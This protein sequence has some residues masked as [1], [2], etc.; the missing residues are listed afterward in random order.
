MSAPLTPDR[1]LFQKFLADMFEV[2]QSGVASQSLAATLRL[3]RLISSGNVN[4]DEGIRLVAESAQGVANAAGII[5]GIL[6]GDRL[7][8]RACIGNAASS[9]GQRGMATVCIS[10]NA[11]AVDGEIL[12]VENSETDTRIESAVCRQ[13]G[14][15]A[16]L[17]LPIYHEG[18]VSGVLGVVFDAPH[19]FEPSEVRSYRLMAGLVDEAI[20]QV[21]QHAP[22]KAEAGEIAPETEP[23]AE[24]AATETPLETME[25]PEFEEAGEFAAPEVLTP[26]SEERIPDDVLAKLAVPVMLPAPQV[27]R[28]KTIL[29][30]FNLSRRSPLPRMNWSG[31]ASM[32]V[33]LVIVSW[34]ALGHRR[35]AQ[36][37]GTVAPHGREVAGQQVPFASQKQDTV[38]IPDTQTVPGL[39]P[40][41]VL[42]TQVISPPVE[43]SN[44]D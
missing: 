41:D 14:A 17:I 3:H 15:Q 10:P 16:L 5:I 32:A 12:R 28:A 6:R 27:V 24:A 38:S 4:A 13:F 2:Q 20:S 37:L 19:S 33:F 22:E 31:V 40:G 42:P 30:I 23:A 21:L 29:P 11:A 26:F 35:P 44:E 7:I 25:T 39:H 1:E 9:V 18:R 36:P 43:A 34:I 8:Y